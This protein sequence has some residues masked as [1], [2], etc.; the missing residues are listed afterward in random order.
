MLRGKLLPWNLRL[1]EWPPADKLWRLETVGAST[2]NSFAP[3]DWPFS[4][5]RREMEAPVSIALV[6]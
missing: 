4:R 1:A 6:G 5:P 2:Q 3:W